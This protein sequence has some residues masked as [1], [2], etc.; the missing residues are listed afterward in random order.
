MYIDIKDEGKEKKYIA[1]TCGRG[2]FFVLERGKN[3]LCVFFWGKIN[4]YH[5]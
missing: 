5:T 1:T 3:P 2:F 4:S